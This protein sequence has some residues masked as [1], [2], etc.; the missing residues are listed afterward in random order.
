MQK[1]HIL[2]EHEFAENMITYMNQHN[3]ES[4]PKAWQGFGDFYPCQTYFVMQQRAI[5]IKFQN[6]VEFVEVGIS[7]S[8][9]MMRCI[10]KVPGS[11][12]PLFLKYA[13]AQSLPTLS[14]PSIKLRPTGQ[15]Y[16]TH[17]LSFA[18]SHET[19]YSYTDHCNHIFVFSHLCESK[20]SSSEAYFQSFD[21]ESL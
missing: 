11:W 5:I 4:Q 20:T 21:L 2:R 3:V 15:T 8:Q 17:S 6:R 12:K 19:I 14:D 9:S 16:L 13:R 18:D 1:I 7:L 10:L